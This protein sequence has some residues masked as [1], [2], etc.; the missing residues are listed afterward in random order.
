MSYF[1]RFCYLLLFGYS[2]L[3]ASQNVVS[4]TKTGS[5][6]NAKAV[7]VDNKTISNVAHISQP[8]IK[9]DDKASKLNELLN[10]CEHREGTRFLV[11]DEYQLYGF[12][13]EKGRL[14][15]NLNA[16]IGSFYPNNQG[17]IDKT[18]NHKVASNTCVMARSKR[19]VIQKLIEPYRFEKQPI[20]FGNFANDIAVLFYRNDPEMSKYLKVR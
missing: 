9:V 3:S 7:L 4:G 18:A 15:E 10:W 5:A 14:S 8:S 19:E 11:S 20:I 12:V 17:F 2:S 16:L 13:T 1:K 6:V